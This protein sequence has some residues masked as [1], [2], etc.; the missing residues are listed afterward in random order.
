MHAAITTITHDFFLRSFA[1][2]FERILVLPG[3]RKWS[4]GYDSNSNL[5]R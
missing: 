5:M 2:G 4:I 3:A 1:L